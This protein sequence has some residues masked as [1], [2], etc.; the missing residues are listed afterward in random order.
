MPSRFNRNYS[1]SYASSNSSDAPPAR[2]KPIKSKKTPKS[3]KFTSFKSKKDEHPFPEEWQKTP[4]RHRRFTPHSLQDL[5]MH[6]L[7]KHGISRET[8]RRLDEMQDSLEEMEDFI[9]QYKLQKTEE[10]EDE[11]NEEN[12]RKVRKR[13]L[14]KFPKPGSKPKVTFKP[15]EFLIKSGFMYKKGVKRTAWKKRFFKIW[16]DDP[17]GLYYYPNPRAADADSR[18]RKADRVGKRINLLFASSGE[19]KSRRTH[20]NRNILNEFVFFIQTKSLKKVK[21]SEDKP[22]K[23]N[24]IYGRRWLLCTISQS[25]KDYWLKTLRYIETRTND[26]VQEHKKLIQQG[27]DLKKGKK[28]EKDDDD[29]SDDEDKEKETVS[30]EKFERAQ[31]I[32]AYGP[33]LL[34]GKAGEKCIFYIE[35][36]LKETLEVEDISVVVET[37]DLHYDLEVEELGNDKFKVQFVPTRKGEYE[38]TVS[39]DGADIYGSPF[40]LIV[41]AGGVCAPRCLARGVGL[42]LAQTQRNSFIIDLKNQFDEKVNGRDVDQQD[43]GLQIMVKGGIELVGEARGNG[44]G[45]GFVKVMD[46]GSLLVEYDYTVRTEES[47]ELEISVEIDDK[48]NQ[49]SFYRSIV[50]S[51]FRPNI[52]LQQPLPSSAPGQAAFGYVPQAIPQAAPAT[53]PQQTQPQPEIEIPARE[54]VVSVSRAEYQPMQ[55]DTDS[56]LPLRLLGSNNQPDLGYTDPTRPFYPTQP[57]ESS[58]LL[59]TPYTETPNRERERRESSVSSLSSISSFSSL[60]RSQVDATTPKPSNLSQDELK[61]L[62]SLFYDQ[63]YKPTIDLLL[64]TFTRDVSSSITFMDMWA[65]YDIVPT[66]I[67]KSQLVALFERLDKES[68]GEVSEFDWFVTM[69]IKVC[70]EVLG[71]GMFVGLYNT[72]KSRVNVLLNTWRFGNK[73]KLIEV[74]KKLG[75]E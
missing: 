6:S 16:L 40:R 50:G 65:M 49:P 34:S 24:T 27:I 74:R 52:L 63:K 14:A 61:E 30:E 20:R 18:R 54:E 51:P 42:V 32:R 47:G 29:K 10:N 11:E 28:K 36:L 67:S 8:Q 15:D 35:D 2:R 38:L 56:F 43:L 59:G 21:V 7:P 39:L 26:C 1:A 75:F 62:I 37:K 45:W 17:H 58:V 64:K 48:L 5:H 57:Q 12:S 72:K 55:E 41:D 31:M 23:V 70:V 3:H 73:E 71:K 53:V 13:I 19:V 4:R 68:E 9:S 22:E 25:E 66:F 69:L 46:D 60:T 33:G 44:G